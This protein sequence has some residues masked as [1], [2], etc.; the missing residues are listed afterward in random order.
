M[1]SP[2]RRIRLQRRAYAAKVRRRL[3]VALVFVAAGALHFVNPE[4]YETIMPPGLPAP[5]ALVYASGV[6]EMAGGL[7]VL[8]PR[9]ARLAGWW[10]IA[11]LV[12][13]FPANV[14]MA[15]EAERFASVPEW[16][17][18]ARLPLQGLL[19]AWVHRATVRA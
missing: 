17:L 8:H 10:L 12:G 5:R 15:V 13:V 16:V 9:T 6:A 18:W 14:Y 4:P 1:R 11:T 7:G 3:P 2:A 19:I